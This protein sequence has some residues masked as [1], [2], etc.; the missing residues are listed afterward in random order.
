M[1]KNDDK[2]HAT[3]DPKKEPQVFELK[4]LRDFGLSENQ[5]DDNN[6][7]PL[8]NIRDKRDFNNFDDEFGALDMLKLDDGFSQIN[9]SSIMQAMQ[10][11]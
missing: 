5:N 1:N 10:S 9:Q 2:A 8:L 7:G 3:P 6:A 11:S 4:V